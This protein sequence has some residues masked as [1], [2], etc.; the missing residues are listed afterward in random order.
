[1]GIDGGFAY[2]ERSLTRH[3]RADFEVTA[4]RRLL[5]S[6]TSLFDRRRERVG[7]LCI[8]KSL[9]SDLENVCSLGLC[10]LCRI[11]IALTTVETNVSICAP[12]LATMLGCWAATSDLHSTNQCSEAAQDLYSCMTTTV[13]RSHCCFDILP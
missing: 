11:L 1:M 13:R 4:F 7:D 9:E 5:P 8:S 6:C 10:S 3:V 2:E 12:Q